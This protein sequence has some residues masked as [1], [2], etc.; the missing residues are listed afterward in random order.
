[1]ADWLAIL[2]GRQKLLLNMAN[3]LTTQYSKYQY[4]NHTKSIIT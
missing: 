2:Y 4:G 1:M 3:K